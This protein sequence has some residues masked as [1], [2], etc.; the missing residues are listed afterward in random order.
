MKVAER[1]QATEAVR[2]GAESKTAYPTIPLHPGYLT[3]RRRRE[4]ILTIKQFRAQVEETARHFYKCYTEKV[5]VV[6]WPFRYAVQEALTEAEE[7]GYKKFQR[8]AKRRV[9]CDKQKEDRA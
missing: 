4:D 2:A 8:A 9:S 6:D 5:G 1:N 3:S 7:S